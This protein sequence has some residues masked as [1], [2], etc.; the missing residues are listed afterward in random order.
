M[1]TCDILYIETSKT[2]YEAC[3]QMRN[4]SVLCVDTEFHRETTYYPEFALL[5]AYAQQRCWLIDPLAIDDLGPLWEVLCDPSILKVF[6]AARQ[7]LE[8]I[9]QQCGQLPLPVF[10]TQIAASLLGHGQQIGFGNLAQRILKKNLGKQESYSDW[11]ARP[12][13]SQQLSYAA[14]DVIYLMPIYQALCEQLEARGRLGW[15]T[16]EQAELCDRRSYEIDERQIFWRVKGVNRLRGRTLAVLR[17][18]A[19]WREVEA[20]KRNLPRRRLLQDEVLVDMAR[21]EHLDMDT[22]RRMRGLSSGMLR[23]FGDELLR[24]WQQGRACEKQDW[25]RSHHAP[26]HSAGTELRMELM[27][28]LVRL[29]AKECDVASCILVRRSELSA[30]AS[31][32]GNV[33]GDPPTLECLQG[34]RHEL[35]GRDLLRLLHGELCLSLDA[36]SGLPRISALPTKEGT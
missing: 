26:A 17:E 8:I 36:G 7:D 29:R 14:N 32:G 15:L 28:T 4:Q 18:L 30:L 5:Q 2:L 3:Q 6:H 20:R 34:W 21:R 33:Q 23:R 1:P 35:I 22:M 11:M 10:D 12:L 19:A 16:Q 9:L 24:A 13:R 31:W 27:D 25:P